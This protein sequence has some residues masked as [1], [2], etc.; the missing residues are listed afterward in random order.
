MFCSFKFIDFLCNF[1]AAFNLFW[2]PSLASVTQQQSKHI[3]KSLRQQVEETR[4][5]IKS[6]SLLRPHP[7]QRSDILLC[8]VY[9]MI[10]LHKALGPVDGASPRC[11][12]LWVKKR[13][14]QVQ[15]KVKLIFARPC[16]SEMHLGTYRLSGISC[17]SLNK[18]I[19]NLYLI[20]QYIY[21][22]HIH[23]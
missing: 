12:S 3:A 22:V 15:S 11:T 17:K 1:M 14:G 16:C 19:Y 4:H 9:Y 21:F 18:I 10:Y 20:L 7:T 23:L 13:V 8:S 2:A 5:R 6:S